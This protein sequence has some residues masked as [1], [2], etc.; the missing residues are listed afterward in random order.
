MKTIQLPDEIVRR[1]EDLSRAAGC[2]TDVYIREALLEKLDDVEDIE[3]AIERL[4]NPG[5][6]IPFDEV[7][8]N[9][10]LDD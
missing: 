4:K 2:D 7:K 3:I 5:R 9:L 1:Y 6:I 10:G 8:K